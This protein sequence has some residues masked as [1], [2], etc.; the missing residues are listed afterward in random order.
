MTDT[1]APRPTDLVALVTFD[2]EVRENLAITRDHLGVP[3]EPPRPLAAALEQWLHLGRRMWISLGGREIR[4][5][6]TAR[7]LSRTAWEIDTLVDAPEG[8]EEVI[9]DLLRQ[10]GRA[11]REATVTRVLLRTPVGS[12][13]ALSAPR[14]GF[15][16][17]VEETLWMGHLPEAV[18]QS[19]GDGDSAP[20]E[21]REA[22]PADTHAR[23]QLYSRAFPVTAREALAMT[24]DEWQGIEDTRWVDRGAPPSLVEEARGHV[25]AVLRASSR[26]QF[27]L[28]ADPEAPGAGDALLQELRRRL[29]HSSRDAHSSRDGSAG[30]VY[31]LMVSGS[32]AEE[33]ARR[34]GL[35]PAGEYGLFCLRVS[36]PI[37]EEAREEAFARAGIAI[38]GS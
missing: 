22:T 2:E 5:I 15:R 30:A 23:F 28:L 18:D 20:P 29:P 6:A 10:A 34:A 38:P 9:V 16:H 1:R 24:Q 13:A 14:A 3:N 25:R 36:H 35:Q 32:A 19:T 26:G 12:P 8:G 21:V 27:S 11:A 33:A 17:V 37:R 4:G 7:E 31:G